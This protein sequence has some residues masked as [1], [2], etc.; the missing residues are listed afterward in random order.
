VIADAGYDSDASVATLEARGAEPVITPSRSRK[1]VRPVGWRL[2]RERNVAERFPARI[3]PDRRVATRSDEQ[4]ANFPASV[5]GGSV[6]V[7][8]K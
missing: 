1:T 6:M 4:A 8:L 3:K 7:M 2:Y 5:Q